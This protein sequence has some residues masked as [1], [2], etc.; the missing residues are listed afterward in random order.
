VS[1][2]P[3]SCSSSLP[4]RTLLAAAVSSVLIAQALSRPQFAVASVK[5]NNTGC[6]TSGG[7]GNGTGGGRNVTLKNLIGTAYQVQ[8][9]Q[10]A[11][12]PG[13]VGSDRFDV[14]GKSEDP[15]ASFA[16]LRLMLQSLL[17]ERFKL[18]VRREERSGTV[19]ALVVAKRG[20]K[21]KLAADQDSPDVNGPS[22]DGIPARGNVR[23]ATGSLSG[24]AV[25]LS[26]LAYF[27]S[28]RMDRLV[29]DKTGLS[30]RFD[31]SVSWIPG[32]G[33]NPLDP[34]G[35]ELPPVTNEQGPTIF[36]A[37]E[38]QLGLRLTSAEPRL[39]R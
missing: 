12:G 39:I 19:Y 29:I 18:K 34:G 22:K 37:L 35:N 24:Y 27:L 20:P 14:E 28:Q 10:I 2:L 8:Q 38:E 17:E 33:E 30:G 5:P 23:F 3:S 6:C 16:D 25:P 26:R 21:L 4:C 32:P 15:K 36:T 13:W 9:F 11:G 1:W 31:V 7:V